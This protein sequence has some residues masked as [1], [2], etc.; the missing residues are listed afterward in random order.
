MYYEIYLKRII[1]FFLM[2][3]FGLQLVNLFAL[4]DIP[5]VEP[6]KDHKIE[7]KKVLKCGVE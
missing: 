1:P 5:R 6:V 7:T 2:F 3:L 4:Q